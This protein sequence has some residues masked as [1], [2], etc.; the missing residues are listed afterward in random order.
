MARATLVGLGL[1]LAAAATANA[2]SVLELPDGT[3]TAN[4]QDSGTGGSQWFGE[5]VTTLTIDAQSPP[6][7]V[8]SGR[9]TGISALDTSNVEIGLIPKATWD[10]W[11]TAYGG[12]WKSAVFSKGLYV[13]HWSDNGVGL[14]LNED[15]SGGDDEPFAWP[16]DSPSTGDPWEF[17][18]TMVPSASGNAYL[19]VDGPVDTDYYETLDMYGTQPFVYSGDYSECYLIAQIWS[20]TEDATFS[21]TDV[22]AEPVPEPFSVA[23]LFMAV[24]G[25]RLYYRRKRRRPVALEL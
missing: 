9:I 10:N 8:V 17:S 7:A 1:L 25:L 23:M 13:V 21:F 22:Q 14:S 15:G 18:F 4:R 6:G 20:A 2:G 24:G 3:V 16:L 12:A 5:S 11:Q 19:S